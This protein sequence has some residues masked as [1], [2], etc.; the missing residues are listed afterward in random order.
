MCV[1]V[2]LVEPDFTRHQAGS[3]SEKHSARVQEWL[4][5]MEDEEPCPYDQTFEIIASATEPPRAKNSRP[6]LKRKLS[7]GVLDEYNILQYTK[8]ATERRKALALAE[9]KK[10]RS[11]AGSQTVEPVKEE[12]SASHRSEESTSFGADNVE[13]TVPPAT[14]VRRKKGPVLCA[15]CGCS[16]SRLCEA[17]RVSEGQYSEETSLRVVAVSSCCAISWFSAFDVDW[18]FTGSA[19]RGHSKGPSRRPSGSGSALQAFIHGCPG[20]D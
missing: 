11:D 6:G 7:N 2:G 15:I 5:F 3:G 13:S 16:F 18:L 10:Q 1:L 20:H 19:C 14:S 12:K 17:I 8:I 4:T 9:V